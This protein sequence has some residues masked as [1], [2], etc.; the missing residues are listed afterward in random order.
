MDFKENYLLTPTSLVHLF[1]NSVPT[2]FAK[3]LKRVKGIY[4][5]GKDMVYAGKYYDVLRDETGE[6]SITLLVPALL[7]EQLQN[8]Q[9]IELIGFLQKRVQAKGARIDLQLEIMEIIGQ[10]Q[11]AFNEDELKAFEV[12]QK[13]RDA[14]Y[15]DVD[16][17][18]KNRILNEQKV[19]IKILV[20]KTGII[21]SDIKEQLKDA[22]GFYDIEF[23]GIN[24]S[25]ENEI[26]E[27]LQNTEADVIAIARGGGDRMEIF[28]KPAIAEVAIN[29][30]A[31]FIT[32]LGHAQDVP[33]L[34]KVA[35]KA[36]TTP[37]AFGQHLVD[38]F[39]HTI[40]E[41]SKSKAGIID[42][43]TK[44]LKPLYE[45]QIQNLKEEAANKEKNWLSEKQLLEDRVKLAQEAQPQ[46]KGT[47]WALVA[48]LILLGI[49]GGIAVGYWLL[50]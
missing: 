2:D 3:D 7:R 34:Q 25:N 19:S 50:K 23:I 40:E 43:V 49:A 33:L 38:L 14:G 48:L 22:I 18:I 31:Y 5:Q 36:F 41:R 42:A 11:A 46:V 45:K 21:H 44:S 35:D 47:N 6:A 10:A 13:K 37:T 20:G 8:N 17:F 27:A 39:N 32:A 29:L 12:L 24:L 9:V 26:I 30:S 28:D 16:G 4:V 15:L 1:A